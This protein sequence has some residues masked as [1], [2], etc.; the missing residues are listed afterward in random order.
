MSWFL[1]P[2]RY[3]PLFKSLILMFKGKFLEKKLR[4]S[5]AG[6]IIYCHITVPINILELLCFLLKDLDIC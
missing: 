4:I 5:F 2:K 1:T 3:T 6:D